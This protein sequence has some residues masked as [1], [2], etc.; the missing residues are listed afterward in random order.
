[1]GDAADDAHVLH[2]FKGLLQQSSLFD[3]ARI[4]DIPIT[5]VNDLLT[6]LAETDVVVATRFHNAL[7]A[8]VLNRPVILISFHQKCDSLMDQ[9]GLSDYCEDINS[10]S[11]DKLVRQFVRLRQNADMLKDVTK[12]KANEQR[13]ALEQQYEIIFRG[14]GRLL[15][16]ESGAKDH[17][18]APRI[19]EV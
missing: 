4:I 8:L 10:L 11:T 19:R 16:G 9:M 14:E 5:T 15:R 1:M 12:R 7:L 18:V 2:E 17:S 3:P 13:R 6:R